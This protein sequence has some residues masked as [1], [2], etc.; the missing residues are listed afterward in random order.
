M[1]KRYWSSISS[2]AHDLVKEMVSSYF[3]YRFFSFEGGLRVESFLAFHIFIYFDVM[4]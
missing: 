2:E 3:N 1:P 4:L